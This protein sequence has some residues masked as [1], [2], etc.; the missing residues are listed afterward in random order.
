MIFKKPYAFLIKNFKIINISLSLLLIFLTYKLNKLSTIIS[1]IYN[2]TIT[3]NSNLNKEYIG[4]KMFLLL[5]FTIIL[6]S[7]IILLLKKKKK[8]LYDYIY[9][10]IYLVIIILYLMSISNVFYRINDSIIE[11]SKLKLYVDVSFLVIIPIY[12]FIINY[13]LIGIGFNIKKFNFIEDISEFKKETKDNEEV[14]LILNKNTY[15]YKRGFRKTIRETKYYYLENKNIINTFFT[16]LLISLL[17]FTFSFSIFKTNKAR[18]N[19]EFL[20]SNIFLKINKITETKYDLNNKLIEKNYKFVIVNLTVRG[21]GNNVSNLDLNR[22]RLFYKKEYV[23][24]NNYYNNFFY[25]LGTPY[26]KEEITEKSRNYIIIFKVPVKYKSNRYTLKIYENNIVEANEIKGSYKTINFKSKKIDELVS[27]EKV[28]LSENIVLNKESYGN[29]NLTISDYNISNNYLYDKDNIIKIIKSKDIN[30]TLLILDYTLDLDKQNSISNY[31]KDDMTF[32][33]K[34]VSITY[35]YNNEDINYKSSCIGNIN[36][37]VM[38]SV[39]YEVSNADKI[40]LYI[41]LRN[42]IFVYYL[43]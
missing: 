26:D 25:D 1:K 15:K 29:T 3:N 24:A 36:N 40:K 14:E 42:R 16:I 10:V 4:F 2:G 18:V 7:L 39:P 35:N 31:F 13:F 32:F 37:K 20:I 33:D 19:R 41:N 27:L 30:K 23:Y 17:T 12:I 9:C 22:F 34:F 43:K 38:L 11:Q 28:N 8:P 6:L 21:N 5:F